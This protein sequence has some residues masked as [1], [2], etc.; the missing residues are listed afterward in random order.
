MKKLLIGII[1][2]T[3]AS[4]AEIR[5]GVDVKI[6][7]NSDFTITDIMFS[8]SENLE[9]LKFESLESNKSVKGFLS[10]KENKFD[11]TYIINFTRENGI[12]ESEKL[13][14]YSNGIPLENLIE[15]NIENDSVIQ[16]IE[17]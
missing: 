14:Y 11:G 13:S 12:V 9:N 16:K 5:G 10:M 6:N 4:C 15:I 17:K 8:T 3:L 7:N 2:L 1:V